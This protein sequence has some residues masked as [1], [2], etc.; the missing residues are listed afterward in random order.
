MRHTKE[1]KRTLLPILEEASPK[2]TKDPAELE[3]ATNIMEV[4]LQKKHIH[5]DQTHMRVVAS[6]Q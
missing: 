3:E 4:T 6:P 1:K 2:Q 5:M